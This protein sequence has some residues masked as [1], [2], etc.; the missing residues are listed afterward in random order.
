MGAGTARHWRLV[1]GVGLMVALLPGCEPSP[2]PVELAVTT[3]ADGADAAPGDGV[4]EVTAGA[5][6]CTLRAAV[7]EANALPGDAPVH[8]DL[9][10]GTYRLAVVGSDDA[11][12]GGDLDVTAARTVALR[13]AGRGAVVDAAGADRAIHVLGAT[14]KVRRLG[15]TG[16]IGAGITVA[17]GRAELQASSVHGNHGAGLEVAAGAT[18]T[19]ADSTFSSNLVGGVDNAGT[20]FGVADRKS[21]V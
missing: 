5:G 4:C 6:D 2:P 8:I 14:L 1:T 11:N 12:A 10:E 7:D 16:A 20:Y 15:I 19:S 17:S 18:G 21:V 9:P 3:T 13:G